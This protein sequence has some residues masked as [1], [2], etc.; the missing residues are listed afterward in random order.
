MCAAR[1]SAG[2]ETLA[3][4]FIAVVLIGGALAA[5]AQAAGIAISG[6]F[7]RQHFEMIPG[8]I[9]ATSDVYVV[10]FNQGSDPLRV[11]LVPQAPAGV[12]LVLPYTEFT[13]APGE[14]RQVPVGVSVGPG[15]MPGDYTLAIG[16][17]AYQ[18]G[19]GIRITGGAQQRAALT[20]TG[21]A[22]EVEIMV[23][24]PE[25]ALFAAEVRLY[26]T[27]EGQKQP[28]GYSSTGKLTTKLTPGEYVVEAYYQKGKVAEESFKL[29]K[30]EKK[31][32][33]LVPQ[34]IFI[35][36]FSVAPAY[37][38]ETDEIAFARITYTIDNMYQ[39]VKDARAVLK[40]S[41]GERAIDEIELTSSP[42]LAVGKTTGSYRYTPSQGWQDGTYRFS[43]LLY[44]EGKLYAQSVEVELPVGAAAKAG[45]GAGID[46]R[47]P[48]GIVIAVVI[49]G[50][51]V[52][53]VAMRKRKAGK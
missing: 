25:G 2:I 48:V 16:A 39:P 50:A 1:H 38:N 4:I 3:P 37:R 36:G 21:D 6:N 26:R 5:P 19:E 35:E 7:Y 33:R 13:L 9:L 11:R 18:G 27:V 32:I 49:V 10:V 40:V 12:E 41:M 46:W 24:S 52:Y 22:G 51:I 31:T 15:V 47:V 34:T 8:Q 29:A 43:I 44:A 14:N 20:I 23:V 30:D 45:A 28:C 17:E 53:L 42:T